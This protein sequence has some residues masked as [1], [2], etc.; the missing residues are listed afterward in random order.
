MKLKYYCRKHRIKY[1]SELAECPECAVPAQL[2]QTDM[3]LLR[4]E[5]DRQAKEGK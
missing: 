4:I 2:N 1:L 5:L 3:E